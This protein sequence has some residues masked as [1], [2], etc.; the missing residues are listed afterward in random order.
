MN[1]QIPYGEIYKN[2]SIWAIW[3]AAF[4]VSVTVFVL[5]TNVTTMIVSFTQS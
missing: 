3:I 2:K 5:E 1:F 4:G